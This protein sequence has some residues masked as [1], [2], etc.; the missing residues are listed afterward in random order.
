MAGVFPGIIRVRCMADKKPR[1][2][3][4]ESEGIL[5]RVN[6][7]VESRPLIDR[8]KKHFKA[9]DAPEDDWAEL[10]GRRIGRVL[11]VVLVILVI[12]WIFSFLAESGS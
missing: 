7:E 3:R 1:D 8:T 2:R 5:D 10:W 9:D 11:S 6:R 12:G 4:N